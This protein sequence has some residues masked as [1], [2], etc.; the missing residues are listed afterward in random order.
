MYEAS[1][2]E[3]KAVQVRIHVTGAEELSGYP[4]R[5]DKGVAAGTSVP[6]LITRRETAVC[7]KWHVRWCERGTK[8]PLHD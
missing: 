6:R 8:V 1:T 5:R 2:E 4:A 7:H 3:G